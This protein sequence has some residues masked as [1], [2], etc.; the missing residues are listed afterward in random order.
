MDEST[1]H[2]NVS[3]TTSD[4]GAGG[5]GATGGGVGSLVG[6]GAGGGVGS[7]AGGDAGSV[8]APSAPLV[9]DDEPP[10][11]VSQYWPTISFWAAD[12]H[13][14]IPRGLSHQ[15]QAS[16]VESLA[17]AH[18]SDPTSVRSD[19]VQE[20]WSIQPPAAKSDATAGASEPVVSRIGSRTSDSSL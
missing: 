10:H 16:P 20:N 6:A 15:A 3:G 13:A 5:V 2:L 11:S 19:T 7:G 9:D 14:P 17:A 12:T 1:V 8:P 4:D 18:A